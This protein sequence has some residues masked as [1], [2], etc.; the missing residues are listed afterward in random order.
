MLF[1]TFFG[2]TARQAVLLRA[3]QKG[4]AR[5]IRGA[6]NATKPPVQQ[7]FD[8]IQDANNLQKRNEAPTAA[9][10]HGRTLSKRH[11]DSIELKS[12]MIQVERA[13]TVDELLKLQ[14]STDKVLIKVQ[15]LERVAQKI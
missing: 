11:E 6:T 5:N 3:C 9:T 12:Q 15:T 8:T 10:Q 2:L 4:F 1:S 14:K 7:K 13:E